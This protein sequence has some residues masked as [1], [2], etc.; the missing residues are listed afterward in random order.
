MRFALRYASVD[1][2]YDSSPAQA[3]DLG[4]ALLEGGDYIGSFA[5]RLVT[6]SREN[7]RGI[8]ITTGR[9][10]DALERGHA[11]RD[12]ARLVYESNPIAPTAV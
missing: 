6:W 7:D 11:P 5:D 2:L 8:G 9:V 1:Q 12:A 3:V 4:E 10:I